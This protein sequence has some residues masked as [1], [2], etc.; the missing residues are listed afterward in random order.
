M[1]KTLQRK[2]RNDLKLNWKQFFAVWLVVVLGTGFYGAMYP[3]GVNL[4]N[5]INNG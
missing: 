1:L 2:T 5:I 3:A 4:L